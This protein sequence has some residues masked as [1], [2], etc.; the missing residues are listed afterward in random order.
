MEKALTLVLTSQELR[1]RMGQAGLAA[2]KRLTWERAAQQ[3]LGLIQTMT[4]NGKSGRTAIQRPGRQE[5][6][7]TS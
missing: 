3:L 7:P 6:E 1:Q 2:V 4:T 5:Y